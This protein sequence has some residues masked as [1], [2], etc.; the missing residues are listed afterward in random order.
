MA[1][2]PLAGKPA[3]LP[4]GSPFP[5]LKE[6][7]KFAGPLPFTFDYEEETHSIVRIQGVRQRWNPEP[8]A[9]EVDASG[10]PGDGQ[11]FAD[12]RHV[13]GRPP[14]ADVAVAVDAAEF[15][16]R[17]VERVGNLAAAS[18]SRDPGVPERR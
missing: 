3:P 2:H 13:S 17:L 1:I 8:V 16:R 4:E 18:A 11:T 10:D 15:G 14:N 9:V 12:W 5:D 6:A 7:R